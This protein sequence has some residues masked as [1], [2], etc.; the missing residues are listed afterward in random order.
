MA[1]SIFT[2]KLSMK[3]RDRFLDLCLLFSVRGCLSVPLVVTSDLES[4]I[5]YSQLRDMGVV[6]HPD[7]NQLTILKVLSAHVARLLPRARL[8]LS[9]EDHLLCGIEDWIDLQPCKS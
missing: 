8:L 4:P 3:P 1:F 9:R 5:R 7:P 6:I 2:N